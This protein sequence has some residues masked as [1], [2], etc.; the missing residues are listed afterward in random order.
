MLDFDKLVSTENPLPE[1]VVANT[2]WRNQYY[3]ANIDWLIVDAE[4]YP[5][6]LELNLSTESY[7]D[8]DDTDSEFIGRIMIPY[9][10]LSEEY[11]KS[12]DEIKE[13]PIIYDNEDVAEVFD[14]RIKFSLF[15]GD[16][17]AE[18]YEEF[19]GKNCL[20]IENVIQDLLNNCYGK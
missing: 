14:D 16:D 17:P 19:D 11:N 2:L 15:Q 20:K 8:G 6:H 10:T 1:I 5:N 13:L 7:I 18:W 3:Q 12:V 4:K 9:T